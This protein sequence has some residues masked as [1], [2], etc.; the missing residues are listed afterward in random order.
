MSFIIQSLSIS[1][2]LIKILIWPT[3]AIPSPKKVANE[4]LSLPMFPELIKDQIE[5]V[6]KKI[7]SFYS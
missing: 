5:Y 3:V 1:R 2:T 6:T 4:I 7:K